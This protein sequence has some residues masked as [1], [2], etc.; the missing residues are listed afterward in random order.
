MTMIAKAETKMKDIPFL[1]DEFFTTRGAFV[2]VG[3][4]VVV[5]IVGRMTLVTP[6]IGVPVFGILIRFRTQ[7]SRVSK[8]PTHSRTLL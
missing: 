1:P 5:V 7:S 3:L 8:G 4:E 2:F 6:T